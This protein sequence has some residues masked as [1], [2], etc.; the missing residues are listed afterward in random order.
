MQKLTWMMVFLTGSLFFLA[1]AAASTSSENANSFADT[2]VNWHWPN[3]PESA[4]E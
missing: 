3:R 1:A 2:S 4:A